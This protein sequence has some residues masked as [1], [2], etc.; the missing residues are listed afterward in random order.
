[1][2]E[3]GRDTHSVTFDATKERVYPVHICLSAE[4]GIRTEESD[5]NRG[6]YTYHDYAAKSDEISILAFRNRSPFGTESQ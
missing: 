1:M 6:A 3:H 2:V 4:K 5:G